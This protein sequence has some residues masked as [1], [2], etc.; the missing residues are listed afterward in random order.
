MFQ[1]F[2]SY[3]EEKALAKLGLTL[4]QTQIEQFCAYGDMLLEWNEKVNLTSIVEPREVILKHFIDSL[5]LS[6]W[7][8]GGSLADIGTGAGFPGIPLKICLP[9]LEVLLLDSLGK[10][11]DFLNHVLKE[12]DLQGASAV[13]A[14]AEEAGRNKAYR[15]LFDYTSSRAVARLPVLLEYAIPLTKTGGLFLAAK[16][17]QV[18]EEVEVST[19]ALEILGCSILE[20]EQYSLGEEAE[21]RAVIVV[22]KVKQTPAAYP[23]KPGIPGKKPL[24]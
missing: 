15:E 7:I 10:R 17:A 5:A 23:R 3:L 20:I 19:K 16:G 14:R 11:I 6:R 1:E 22:E 8:K 12:L 4:T 13:H 24:G 9:E 18:D 2:A 21:H